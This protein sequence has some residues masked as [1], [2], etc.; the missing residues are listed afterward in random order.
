MAPIATTSDADLLEMA[1]GGDR[2]AFDRL[3]L[4]HDERMRSLAFRLLADADAMDLVLQQAY[5]AAYTDLAQV[6]PGSDFG[7]WLYRIV[8]N[9]CV[10]QMRRHPHA[11]PARLTGNVTTAEVVRRALSELP[12]AQRVTVVMVD[13]EGFDHEKV[14]EI[15]GVAPDTVASRL[16]RAR[17]KLRRVLWDEVL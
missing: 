9:R 14:S 2:F 16:H 13:G 7:R 3:L 15:L 11:A 5:V 8:Y 4:R 12:I 10:D 1:R 6:G 17:T